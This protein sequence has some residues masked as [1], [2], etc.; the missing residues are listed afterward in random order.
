MRALLLLL[1][2][3]TP[4]TLAGEFLVMVPGSSAA[5]YDKGRAQYEYVVANGLNSATAPNGMRAAVFKAE[6][7]DAIVNDLGTDPANG[8]KLAAIESLDT[9]EACRDFMATAED[10][11][12]APSCFVTWADTTFTDCS[13]LADCSVPGAQLCSVVGAVKHTM[14]KVNLAGTTCASACKNDDYRLRVTCP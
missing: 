1:C 9:Y 4:A 2:M 14:V 7:A 5:Q 12:A 11:A 8:A 10:T 13:T 3:S 6:K